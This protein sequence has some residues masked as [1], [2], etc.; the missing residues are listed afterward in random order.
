MR[1]GRKER[2]GG[3]LDAGAAARRRKP[4][5]GAKG[6]PRGLRN[7]KA[8]VSRNKFWTDMILAYRAF[9]CNSEPQNDGI[10]QSERLKRL[11]E[12]AI[13]Q[14]RILSQVGGRKLLKLKLRFRMKL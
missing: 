9:W 2:R 8:C 6:K 11:N 12:I 5:A 1:R 4:A 3:V 7:G 10:P 13:H 14:M